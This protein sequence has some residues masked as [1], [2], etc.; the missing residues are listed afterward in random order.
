MLGVMLVLGSPRSRDQD[1]DTTV[2]ERVK[3]P[4]VGEPS[5]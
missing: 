3:E 1:I 2:L 4:G 5:N